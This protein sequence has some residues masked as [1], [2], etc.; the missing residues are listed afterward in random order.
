MG[1]YNEELGV[2]DVTWLS[3]CGNEMT[4]EQWQDG[5][6]RCLG[7]L[8][9]GRAQPTGIRRSGADATPPAAAQRPP[10]R[11]QL[12]PAGSGPGHR[13]TLLLDTNRP[14]DRSLERFEFDT[15]FTLTNR[16][17]LLFELQRE[18]G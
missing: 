3:P 4:E 7:M 2:K 8:M 1:E 15:E 5:N 10:R 17:L 13:L 9:D 6:A 11:G 12:P 16:S 18:D 14:D